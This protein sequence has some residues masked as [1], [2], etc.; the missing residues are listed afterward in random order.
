MAVREALAASIT[1]AAE[2]F[3]GI[4]HSREIL[5]NTLGVAEDS[6]LL[7]SFAVGY[8]SIGSCGIETS[9]NGILI[10]DLVLLSLS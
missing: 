6:S 1:Q 10:L 7:D 2:L 5:L 4:G 8:F 9:P 3:P